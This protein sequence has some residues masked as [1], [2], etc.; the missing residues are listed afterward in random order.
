[1][2]E[3]DLA[4]KKAKEA[5]KAK[6]KDKKKSPKPQRR[7]VDAAAISPRRYAQMFFSFSFS[8]INQKLR[9]LSIPFPQS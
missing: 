8:F 3:D 6:D 4:R 9:R 5:E 2:I 1:M 7:V